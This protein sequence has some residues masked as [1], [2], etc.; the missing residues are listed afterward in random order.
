[1][2]CSNIAV[3]DLEKLPPCPE[4]CCDRAVIMWK[5]AVQEVRKGLYRKGCGI[6]RKNQDKFE[7]DYCE[8]FVF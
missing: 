5:G 1:M 8:N 7:R 6:I 3:S 2:K 4:K